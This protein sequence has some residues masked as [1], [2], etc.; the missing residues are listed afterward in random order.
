MA[1]RLSCNDVIIFSVDSGVVYLN[2]LGDLCWSD[3]SL[4]LPQTPFRKSGYMSIA[5]LKGNPA[6]LVHRLVAYAKY[7]NVLFEEKMC[8]NHIDCDHFNNNASN[9]EVVTQS[10]NQKYRGKLGRYKIYN[11]NKK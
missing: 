7:G 4:V 3:S 11:R 6:V 9:I 5:P 1:R 2:S 8:V 10:E